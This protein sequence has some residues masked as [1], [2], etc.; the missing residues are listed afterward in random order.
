MEIDAHRVIEIELHNYVTKQINRQITGYSKKRKILL[1][2][3]ILN[4]LREIYVLR[5]IS[6]YGHS[7]VF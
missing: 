3:T 4:L 1:M 5:A 2:E 7:I 6:S